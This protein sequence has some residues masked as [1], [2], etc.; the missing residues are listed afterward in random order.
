MMQ[1]R[2]HKIHSDYKMVDYYK[3]YKSTGG[4]L[5]SKQF[6]AI[7]KDV[8]GTLGG[9]LITEGFNWRL[10][11]GLGKLRIFKRLTCTSFKDGKL[12]TNRAIDFK[13]T[14][15]LWEVNEDAKKNKTLVY[16]DNYHSDGFVYNIR[17]IKKGANY[18]NKGV[19][20]LQVSRT[21]KRMLASRIKAGKVEALIINKYV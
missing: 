18:K 17:Y 20:S 14:N 15:D 2:I 13:A 11:S 8:M 3:H 16:H 5:T 10:P 19:Y 6:G 7:L 1:T 9:M 12:I 4:K 21:L